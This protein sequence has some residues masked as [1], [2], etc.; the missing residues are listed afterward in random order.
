MLPLTTLILPNWK[1]KMLTLE[2]KKTKKKK[3][4]RTVTVE[5]EEKPCVL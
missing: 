5:T 3:S 2:K 4:E 1:S